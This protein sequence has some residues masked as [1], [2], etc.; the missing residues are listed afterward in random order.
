MAASRSPSSSCCSPRRWYVSPSWLLMSS[1]ALKAAWALCRRDRHAST[2]AR[3]HASRNRP[4][5]LARHLVAT[6][7][8]YTLKQL[9]RLA[10]SAP[11]VPGRLGSGVGVLARHETSTQQQ[12]LPCPHARAER[13]TWGSRSCA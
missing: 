13:R 4:H 7:Q 9:P 2:R 11:L 12:P 6:H 5:R 1:A 10:L 3:E 8:V